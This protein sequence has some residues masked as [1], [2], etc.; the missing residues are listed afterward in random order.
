[1][2]ET[3]TALRASRQTFRHVEGQAENRRE[4][5]PNE[6]EL[7]RRFGLARSQPRDPGKDR[8]ASRPDARAHPPTPV[9]GATATEAPRPRS[10]ATS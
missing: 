4:R 2:F 10:R 7:K 9:A 5:E 1:V 8:P 3:D 6:R